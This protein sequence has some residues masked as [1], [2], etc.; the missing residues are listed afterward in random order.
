MAWSLC[1]G[2]TNFHFGV[3]RE[4]VDFRTQWHRVCEICGA[5]FVKAVDLGW[6]LLLARLL[7]GAGRYALIPPPGANSAFKRAGF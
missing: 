5:I 4:A 7:I 1:G 6:G 3:D 2:M